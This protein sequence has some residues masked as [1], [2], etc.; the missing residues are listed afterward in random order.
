[1]PLTDPTPAWM[2]TFARERRAGSPLVALATPDV[3]A[4]TRAI[5]RACNGS[6]PAAAWS[7]SGGLAALNRPG[8]KG[9][10]AMCKALGDAS[11]ESITQMGD[12]LVAARALPERSVLVMLNAHLCWSQ[13]IVRDAAQA[14][15]DLFKADQRTLVLLAPDV[16]DLPRELVTDLR[17]LRDELPTAAQRRG[18]IG[19]TYGDAA[20]S[21]DIPTLDEATLAEATRATA[22]LTA[23]AVEQATA[24]AIR[25][26]GLDVP[27]LRV[28][29]REAV[30]ARKGLRVSDE[31]VTYD[32]VGGLGA[33]AAYVRALF[34]GPDRPC[35][36]VLIDEI[37]KAL[38]GSGGGDL[39]G[40][41]SDILATLLTWQER[42]KVHAILLMGP[43]GAGKTHSAAAAAGEHGVPMIWCDLGGMKGSLVGETGQNLRAALETI[44]A[45]SEGKILLVATCNGA[46]EL[47][48]EL[49]RRYKPRFV[50]DLPD[51]STLPAIWAIQLRAHGLPADSP[52]PGSVGWTGA[53][54]RDACQIARATGATPREAAAYI[55]P[56]SV[57]AAATIKRV[58]EEATGRFVD[59]SRGGPYMG[60]TTALVAP[61]ETGRAR[62]TT[63]I[64]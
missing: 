46:T 5:A 47:R 17:V 13:P 43:P 53:E 2:E 42:R 44:D 55:V 64:D 41:S 8:E 24:V 40:V 59:A 32:D 48:P 60:P 35:A 49:L 39:S 6:T 9:V 16:A 31:R 63:V 30:N 51:A 25:R 26:E 4:A 29:A 15:R 34:K 20:A 22:G 50:V 21:N 61:P 3:P 57:S 33:L 62:R 18:I 37:E 28:T 1:M 45:V 56:I 52:L 12:A 36:V 10:A 54:I 11:P 58:R 23:F 19:G 27:A 14:L 38:A 7:C